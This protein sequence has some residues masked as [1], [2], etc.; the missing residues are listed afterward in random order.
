MYQPKA[1]STETLLKPPSA[2]S[3]HRCRCLFVAIDRA[4][5]WVFVRIYPTPTAANARRFSWDLD[6]AALMKI[7]RVLP[8]HVAVWCRSFD[9]V[10]CSKGDE[11]WAQ[12]GRM[13]FARMRFGSR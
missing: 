3:R 13:N 2:Q 11:P 5:R 7:T 10:L 6:R 12:S 1:A 9:H 4:T 8:G